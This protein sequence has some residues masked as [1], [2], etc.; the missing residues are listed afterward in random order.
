MIQNYLPLID[1]IINAFLFLECSG[2]GEVNPDSAVRCMEDISSSL[3]ALEQVD[4][5]ALRSHL[6]KIADNSQDRTYS[7]FVRAL[8]DMIGL[9]SAEL[10]T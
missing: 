3:L 5:I 9:A 2:P 4:Q 6:V 7:N 8:P 10:Q 1:G